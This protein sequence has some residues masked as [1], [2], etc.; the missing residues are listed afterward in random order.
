MVVFGDGPSKEIIQAKCNKGGE[1][2]SLEEEILHK[3]CGPTLE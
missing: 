2:V 1:P 3:I